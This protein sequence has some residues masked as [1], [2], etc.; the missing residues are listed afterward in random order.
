MRLIKKMCDTCGC[1]DKKTCSGC[2]KPVDE[3]E[4]KK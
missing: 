4:C 2:G 3:C 1:E